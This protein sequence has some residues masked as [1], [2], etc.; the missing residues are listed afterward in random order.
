M[1]REQSYDQSHH[2]HRIYDHQ[3]KIREYEKKEPPRRFP[4][5]HRPLHPPVEVIDRNDRQQDDQEYKQG[6]Y[7]HN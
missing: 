7:S 6:S 4:G 1:Q 3:Y 2:Q 5:P